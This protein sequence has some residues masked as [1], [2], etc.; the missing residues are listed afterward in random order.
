MAD[1]SGADAILVLP[2]PDPSRD[3]G[4][5]RRQPKVATC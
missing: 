4:A 1:A 2:R 5:P 3:L